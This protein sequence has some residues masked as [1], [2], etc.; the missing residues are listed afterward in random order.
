M[1]LCILIHGV[2]AIWTVKVWCVEVCKACSMSHMSHMVEHTTAA[3]IVCMWPL[4]LVVSHAG[5]ET[6]CALFFEIRESSDMSCHQ[7]I[8]GN[9]Q[10]GAYPRGLCSV[11]T[12]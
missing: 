10:T 1:Q 3:H 5:A 11:V 12:L 6:V 4:G 8:S 2:V 9:I 7:Q